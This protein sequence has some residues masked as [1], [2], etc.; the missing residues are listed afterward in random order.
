MAGKLRVLGKL[1]FL[2]VVE[3]FVLEVMGMCGKLKAFGE[4][5]RVR[6]DLFMGHLCHSPPDKC[7]LMKDRRALSSDV[8]YLF[9]RSLPDSYIS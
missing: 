5:I 4:K 3:W 6:R 1:R 7:F 9:K 2:W 8:D